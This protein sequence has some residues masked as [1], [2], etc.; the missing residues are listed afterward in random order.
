VSGQR[1]SPADFPLCFCP[2]LHL[3]LTVNI[4]H[5]VI[6]TY[7]LLILIMC[8]LAVVYHI[9]GTPLGLPDAYIIL[10]LLADSKEDHKSEKNK[11]HFDQ[12]QNKNWKDDGDVAVVENGE[13]ATGW[14]SMRH[15]VSKS[16]TK[17]GDD[18]LG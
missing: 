18:M 7:G 9:I 6:P 4:H 1:G 13:V 17:R 2:Q 3:L 16:R 5:R 8:L 10:S 12:K 14:A 15:L 11:I